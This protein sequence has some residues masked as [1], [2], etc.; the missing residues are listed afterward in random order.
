MRLKGA[1]DNMAGIL[2]GVG[3]GPG[4]PELMTLKAVRLIKD[5]DWIGIPAKDPASCTAYQIAASAIPQIADKPV[6][7]V[8][9]PMTRDVQRLEEAYREGS[10]RLASILSAGQS[11][12]FLNLG[13]P[14]V[15]GSYMEL[16]KRIL[17][18]GLEAK[19][20][21]GVPS[22]CAVAA[23]LDLPLG[24]GNEMI[25]ILPGCYGVAELD[26]L[27]GTKILMKSASR[28]AD[29]KEAL[30][31]LQAEER[32][33]VR[34]VSNCGMETETVCENIDELPEDAGYFTTILVKE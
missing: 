2:Y 21:S 28:V 13:D 8:P 32:C 12:A 14:T 3:V 17:A 15:Y 11:I 31:R 22:F 7:A 23:A 18:A 26:T 30:C 24:D 4:D 5:C 29:I 27:K 16:H 33:I 25:H 6:A 10:R 19:V 1:D 34:A 9:V 20:I